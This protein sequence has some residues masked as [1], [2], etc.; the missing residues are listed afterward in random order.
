MK[1]F[2]S[3]LHFFHKNIL[4]FTNRPA[5]T[6]DDM[7]E[8]IIN[9]INEVVKPSD[10]LY[11]LGDLNFGKPVYML[12]FFERINCEVQ[13]LQGNHDS[14]GAMRLYRLAPN[15][16]RAEC[17]PYLEVREGGQKLVLCHYPLAVWKNNHHG[18]WHLYGHCHNSYQNVGKSIDVGID[19]AWE[20]YGKFRPLS[21]DEIAEIME[22]R[23]IEVLDHHG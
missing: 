13:L 1:W 18:S 10:I 5:D 7:H 9:N 6:I 11:H 3:D 8:L 21:F 20:N 23:E 12:D 14:D 4:K 16:V 22:T 19:A 15:V 17:S 2:T